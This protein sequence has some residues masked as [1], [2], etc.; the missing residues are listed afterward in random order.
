MN[1]KA[2]PAYRG[3]KHTSG[4]AAYEIVDKLSQFTIENQVLDCRPTSLIS[5][6]GL[7]ML[8]EIFI[9]YDKRVRGALKSLGFKVPEHSYVK[10][11]SL[12]LAEKPAFVR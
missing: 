9:P 10:Y 6:L 8:P 2:I 1:D 5:K 4:E 12:V 7:A 3:I 11:M